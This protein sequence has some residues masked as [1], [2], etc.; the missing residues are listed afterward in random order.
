MIRKSVLKLQQVKLFKMPDYKLT[1]FN[2]TGLGEPIR[3]MLSYG[4][5]DFEDNRISN[6]NW[7]KIKD[8]K[9]QNAYKHDAINIKLRFLQQ[10][11]WVKCLCLNLTARESS[12][13]FRSAVI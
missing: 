8:S 13:R 10:C 12:N 1:Y 3:F 9:R 5:L 2:I 7:P 4:N 11:Q 6:E